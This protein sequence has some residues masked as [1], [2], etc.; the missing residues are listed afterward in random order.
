MIEITG[1]TREFANQKGIHGIDLV[2]KPGEVVGYLG[3][4]GAGKTTTIRTLLGFTKPDAGSANIA[5]LDC[6]HQ[7]SAVH[8]KVGYLSGEIAFPEGMKG[9][10]FL[11]LMREMRGLKDQTRQNEL[12]EL[13]ELDL[14]GPLKKFSK[15]MKQKVG[16]IVALM[17]SPE[18]LI[19]DEPTSGLD[20]LMQNRFVELILAEKA[21]GTTIL[22]SS[23]M[24]EEIE[25]TCDRVV[26]IKEGKIIAD[27]DIATLKNEQRKVYTIQ[28]RDVADV[29]VLQ[30]ADVTIGSVHDTRV[31]VIV[32]GE[33]VPHFIRTLA[34]V[35]FIDFEQQPQSLEN[36]FLHY[37]GEER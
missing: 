8:K 32:S 10:E 7:S 33:Q 17:H 22:M 5:G 2:I 28:L 27:N 13:F 6:T 24:F 20:P 37:Y 1:L 21:K 34:T 11:R 23:H 31:E 36:I 12:I 16:I 19:L 35:D 3:P 14:R 9:H 30:A 18:V 29:A 25:R 4:N 15:G 26:I